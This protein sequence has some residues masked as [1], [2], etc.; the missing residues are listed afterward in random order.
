M[1]KENLRLAAGLIASRISNMGESAHLRMKPLPRIW[2]ARQ[3]DIAGVVALEQDEN[4]V[5]P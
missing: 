4:S 5:A 1:G 3:R 2:W